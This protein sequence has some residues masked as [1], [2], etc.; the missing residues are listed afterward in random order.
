MEN[1]EVAELYLGLKALN[2]E[3]DEVYDFLY[4]YNIDYSN[5]IDKGEKLFKDEEFKPLINELI[6]LRHDFFSSDREIASLYLVLRK[7]EGG[8]IYE[9]R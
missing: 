2:N 5:Y 7:H 3:I 9:D 4:K 1:S 6:K 8:K